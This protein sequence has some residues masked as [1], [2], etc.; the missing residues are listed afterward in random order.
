MSRKFTVLEIGFQDGSSFTLEAN[1][2][3]CLVSL[4]VVA[5]LVGGAARLAVWLL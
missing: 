2:V 5:V 1:P 4:F 3:G